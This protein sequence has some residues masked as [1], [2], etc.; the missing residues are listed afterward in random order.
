MSIIQDILTKIGQAK[1]AP[2]H[3]ACAGMVRTNARTNARTHRARVTFESN[4]DIPISW[5]RSLTLRKMSQ[6]KPRKYGADRYVFTYARA[7]QYYV[8]RL[9]VM[10]LV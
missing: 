8:Y 2:Y 10:C 5:S 7:L 1:L 3:A 4:W 9:E 6:N